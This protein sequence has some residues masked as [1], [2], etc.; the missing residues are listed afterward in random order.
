M[1]D[2]IAGEALRLL[3]LRIQRARSEGDHALA[4]QLEEER[5]ELRDT[6]DHAIP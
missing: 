2:A 3:G 4:K 5:D 6:E 1:S